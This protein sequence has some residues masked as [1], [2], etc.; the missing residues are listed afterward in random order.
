MVQ[1]FLRSGQICSKNF[2][3]TLSNFFPQFCS[4]TWRVVWWRIR[5]IVGTAKER[6]STFVR[7]FSP[8][9]YFHELCRSSNCWSTG[10]RNSW[11]PGD[12]TFLKIKFYLFY[13]L[14]AIL[15]LSSKQWWWLNILL[16][17]HLTYNLSYS[18]VRITGQRPEKKSRWL[19]AYLAALSKHN[20]FVLIQRGTKWSYRT[21]GSHLAGFWLILILQFDLCVSS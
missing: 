13:W 8:N 5:P 11:E 16:D 19:P 2:C 12:A 4:T 18:R 15:I 17:E 9:F 10:C 6:F 1:P 21:I 3:R 7:F 20:L 14:W